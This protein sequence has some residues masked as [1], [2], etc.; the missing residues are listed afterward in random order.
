MA[1]VTSAAAG[2]ARTVK[3][4]YKA[5]TVARVADDSAS[6]EE[7][8]PNTRIAKHARK[9]RPTR[10][11][12]CQCR[13]PRNAYR[14]HRAAVHGVESSPCLRRYGPAIPTTLRRPLTHSPSLAP[15]A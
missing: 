4:A 7:R 10:C 11:R 14:E 12:K 15:F 6:H 13:C 2:S 8:V 1:E 5:G 3:T 9:M